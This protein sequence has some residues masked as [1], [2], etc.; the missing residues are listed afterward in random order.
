M[1]SNAMGGAVRYSNS[2]RR[3][4]SGNRRSSSLMLHP[5]FVEDVGLTPGEIM[6]PAPLM[7]WSSFPASRP[8]TNIQGR[9]RERS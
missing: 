3:Q 8:S 5:C 4:S 1:S 6:R 2:H 7:S 9:N